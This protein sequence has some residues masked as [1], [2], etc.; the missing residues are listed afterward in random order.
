[1]LL[2]FSCGVSSNPLVCRRSFLERSAGTLGLAGIAGLAGCFGDS[3]GASSGAPGSDGEMILQTSGETSAAY[4]MSQVI[5]SAV[6]QNSDVSVDARPSQ[7]T[8]GTSPRSSRAN[9]RS[10]PSRTGRRTRFARARSR[11]GASNTGLIR[12]FTWTTWRGSLPRP[13]MGGR[14]SRISPPRGPCRRRRRAPRQRAGGE[15]YSGRAVGDLGGV[16]RRDGAVVFEHRGEVGEFLGRRVGPES[17]VLGDDSSPV[18]MGRIA[19]STRPS[20][21]GAM[22][23]VR[24]LP[25]SVT[26]LAQPHSSTCS[27]VSPVSASSSFTRGAEIERRRLACPVGRGERRRPRGRCPQAPIRRRECR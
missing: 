9:P 4:S 1:M 22:T 13:T 18:S 17:L 10:R 14:A 23:R 12:C 6:S 8:T 26:C 11:S 5:A 21:V 25:C 16:A 3:G 15:H 27:P 24:L 19:S 7:G 2:L 20:S